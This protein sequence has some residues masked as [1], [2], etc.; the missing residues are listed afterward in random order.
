MWDDFCLNSDEA[1]FWH[2]VRWSKYCVTYRKS[3]RET[4]DY[5]F[6][7]RDDSGVLAIC[8]LFMEK[9]EEKDGNIHIKIGAAGSGGLMI[10]PAL[11]SDLGDDRREKILR[12]VFDH[13]DSL[14]KENR[15]VCAHFRMT[16]LAPRHTPFNWLLKYGCLDSS[17]NT[18]I[19]DLNLPQDRLWSALRKG[20][21]YDTNRG[22][23]NYDINIYDRTNADKEVFDQY[24]LLHHKA[25]GR[26]TR[27][28]ETFEMMYD[29][30]L[31]GN[32]MLCG[33]SKNGV[34][35][36]FSYLILYKDGAYYGSA[37]DD[38]DFET[39]VPI[40]HVIQWSVIQWLKERGYKK[41]EIGQ[42]QFGPQ[43]Y[44]IPS[45]KELSISFFKRGFG[46]MTVP[47]YLGN[48]YYDKDFMKTELENNLQKLTARYQ[49]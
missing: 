26:I 12:L 40:S 25:S 37:S 13:I 11:R 33:V 17:V 28:V 43:I 22:K 16:P 34:F 39:D 41:Y 4:K 29:W 49:V 3:V 15:A 21:K 38:P 2:T 6:F 8:P 5:S 9:C 23:K 14:A 45:S 20:H 18:Q 19:I 46:G 7:V 24:R 27:P 47:C 31:S 32:G 1:W 35:A 48:K 44:D 42:Q 30:I 10:V 36:G